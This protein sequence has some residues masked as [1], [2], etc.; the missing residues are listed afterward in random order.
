MKW[1]MFLISLNSA[2]LRVRMVMVGC[3]YKA[4]TPNGVMTCGEGSFYGKH[5]HD[6]MPALRG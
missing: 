1:I 3:C 4:V 5:L 2:P 6:V